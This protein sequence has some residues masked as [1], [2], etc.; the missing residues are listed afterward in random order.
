ML[1]TTTTPRVYVGTY[2]KYNNGSIKGAWID[3]E[4][5][6]DAKEF[7]KACRE[8]HADE[9]DPEFMLQ[10]W[11]GIPAGMI[12]ESNLSNE[13]WTWLE[14]DDDD[15]ELLS[16]YL[17]SVNQSGDIDEAREAFSGRY[18]SEADWASEFLSDTGALQSV[19]E[20]L[21]SYIDFEAYARDASMGGDMTFVNHD[22]Q[23]WA[24][25]NV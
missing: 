4:D 23:V 3:L 16:V 17:D 5:Y 24:F 25:H 10:D 9:A 13:V 11:E 21:R 19:P 2:D 22:G 15:R 8:L 20:S 14:L 7:Y 6:A 12:G 1:M 18:D